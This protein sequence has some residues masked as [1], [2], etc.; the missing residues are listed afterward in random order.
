MNE[1]LIFME[2]ALCVRVY[3]FRNLD[4]VTPVV[5]LLPE[6]KFGILESQEK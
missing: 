3:F 6:R 1:T 2:E 4:S 5:G